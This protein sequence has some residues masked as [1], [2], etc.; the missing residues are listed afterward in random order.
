MWLSLIC[1]NRRALL[2]SDNIDAWDDARPRDDPF[3]TPLDSV[4]TA[5]VPTHA[6]HCRKCRR[7][8]SF[9]SCDATL[10]SFRSLGPSTV[11]DLG[12]AEDIP[13]N[14]IGRRLV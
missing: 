5:P 4:Q 2:P 6:M 1:T 3:R 8:G 14:K 10:A 11:R 13:G 9:T 12:K 7:F